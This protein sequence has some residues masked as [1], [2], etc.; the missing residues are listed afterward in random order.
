MAEF[1]EQRIGR[2]FIVRVAGELDEAA[3]AAFRERVDQALEQG[4]VRDLIVVMKEVSFIDSSGLG[5]LLGRYKR[6]RE[7][8]GQMGI[9]APPRSV[10]ALLELSGVPKLIPIYRSERQALGANAG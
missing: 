1:S 3:A 2:A 7:L 6:I 5:V 10:R 8:G 9:V 4:G